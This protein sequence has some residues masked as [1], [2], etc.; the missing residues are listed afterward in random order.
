MYKKKENVR[1]KQW[2]TS[3]KA[4]RATAVYQNALQKPRRSARKKE[5]RARQP[6]VKR[7]RNFQK[8]AKGKNVNVVT[9]NRSARR[10]R[11]LVEKGF[12]L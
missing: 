9:V 1:Q 3:V 10:R 7:K 12:V 2:R 8:D 11:A 5:V 6:A 4:H